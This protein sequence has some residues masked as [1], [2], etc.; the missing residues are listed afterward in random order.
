MRSYRTEINNH[1]AVTTIALETI[2]CPNLRANAWVTEADFRHIVDHL[3]LNIPIADNEANGSNSA[4]RDENLRLI[5]KISSLQSQLDAVNKELEECKKWSA[6]I[7]E[8]K[9]RFQLLEIDERDE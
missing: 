3:G 9:S 5:S 8:G 7:P 4:I 2:D 1:Y 6:K